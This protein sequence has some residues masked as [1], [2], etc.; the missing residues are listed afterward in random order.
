LASRS[1]R[2]RSS[3]WIRSINE[4]LVLETILHEG[5]LTRADIARLSGLSKPTVSS[6]VAALASYGLVT[7]AG[8]LAGSLGR[9]GVLYEVNRQAGYLI[10][11]DLGGTKVRAGLA[12]LFGAVVVETSAPTQRDTA[13]GLVAQ[14][15]A[16][17]DELLATAGV[18]EAAL[19]GG[20]LGVPGVYDPETD[21]ITAAYNVPV[22]EELELIATLQQRLGVRVMVDNDVNLA[23]LGEWWRGIAAG[24]EHFVA[25]SIGTGVGMGVVLNGDIYRGSRGGAG[26]IGLLPLGVEDPFDPAHR[27]RGPF[28][29]AVASAGLAARYGQRQGTPGTDPDRVRELFAKARAGDAFALAVVEEE[30]RQVALAIAAVSA[31]LDPQLVVLGGGIGA[32]KILLEPTRRFARQ[33]V[34]QNVRVEVSGLGDRAAF[35]GAVAAGLKVT[36]EALFDTVRNDGRP[37]ADV[38]GEER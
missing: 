15:E 26:E 7:E 16:L 9:P 4:Q 8:Q 12:D 11:Y 18:T 35:Y 25:V 27:P 1:T 2:Q 3:G 22:L 6:V 24:V 20:G 32:Q 17:K 21:R 19:W 38:G 28:E 33:L 29:G 31:V 13:Q 5:S 10:A 14:L 36:R 37:V 23:A 30:A 34:P